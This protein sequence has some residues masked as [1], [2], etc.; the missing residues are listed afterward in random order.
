MFKTQRI[1]ARGGILCSLTA[2]LLSCSNPKNEA[3]QPTASRDLPS[4]PVEDWPYLATVQLKEPALFASSTQRGDRGK[5]LVLPQALQ[6]LEEEQK[7]F[8]AKVQYISP[9]IKVVFRYRFVLNGMTFS[10]PR[11]LRSSFRKLVSSGGLQLSEG[12]KIARAPFEPEAVQTRA[13]WGNTT[14]VAYMGALQAQ[15]ELN[16]YGRGVRVGVVDTG[17]DYNHKMLGGSGRE[18]DYKANDP[19]RVDGEFP[20]SRIRG[21]YDFVGADYD[22][23][24]DEEWKRLPEPDADPLDESGHGTHVA[25][26]IAGVGDGEETYSGVAPEAELYALKV[27]GKKGSTNDSIVIAALEYAADPNGDLDP[28]DSLDIVNLSLGGGYGTP[29]SLYD[30]AIENLSKGGIIAVIA[31]GNSG[32]VPYIVGSPSTSPASI[33]VAASVDAMDQNWRQRASRLD[34]A[35][36]TSLLVPM[37]AGSIVQDPVGSELNRLPFHDIGLGTSDLST[38]DQLALKGKIGLV[39]RGENSFCEK[40]QRI[41][42]AGGL[43]MVVVNNTADAPTLMGGSCTLSIPGIVVSQEVGQKIRA[44]LE[45]VLLTLDPQQYIEDYDKVD[46][47]AGFSSRGPRSFDSLFKPEITAPGAG[48]VSAAVGTGAKGVRLGGTSM[49]TPHV[50]GLVALMKEAF[51]SIGPSEIKSRMMSTAVTLYEDRQKSVP[52]PLTRQGA[53]RVDAYAAL[54]APLTQ[55]PP[56][57]SLGQVQVDQKKAVL[58]RV[59]LKNQT[60]SEMLLKAEA[61]LDSELSLQDRGSFRIAP[62]EVKE[63]KLPFAF[64]ADIYNQ[65][66]REI[67]GF[68]LW[69]D[70]NREG[71]PVVAKLPVLAVLKRVA[72]VNLEAF[73]VYSTSAADADGALA[74]LSFKNSSQTIGTVLPFLPLGEDSRKKGILTDPTQ[75]NSCD[76]E[77]VGYRVRRDASG[78]DYLEWGIKLYQPITSWNLCSVTVFIDKNLNGVADASIAAGKLLPEDELKMQGQEFEELIVSKLG[79]LSEAQAEGEEVEQP[80]A[81]FEGFEASTVALVRV[82]LRELGLSQ[83]RQVNAAITVYARAGGLDSVDSLNRA[84]TDDWWPLSLSKVDVSWR[85]LPDRIEVRGEGETI[86]DIE[87]GYGEGGLLLLIPQNAASES[88]SSR[89]K[90]SILAQPQFGF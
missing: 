34:F 17:I 80:W 48:I 49:A 3:S 12:Q 45:T 78:V 13:V 89:D 85:D 71:A 22:A 62:G 42:D 5:A 27:F 1:A 69:K 32:N 55:D 88:I 84:E 24:A 86:L 74:T 8:L 63:V 11:A 2:A 72:Q 36:G 83:Q 76:L 31:A 90:Q 35:D 60:S 64:K 23:G 10:V 26:T 70:Q 6:K 58:G 9:D 87:G 65:K 52:Y 15:Q 18:E 51:P 57:L 30:S 25:G 47:L 20:T 54:K 28:A 50:A 81:G 56:A 16:L 41:Q 77:R 4:K 44:Q 43:A 73:Q 46:K 29:F 7:A 38:E 79:A 59:W 19:R 21:G 53:G 14:S 40:G 82:P 61:Q 67:D 37:I 39:S 75:S 33:S 68:I 66:A